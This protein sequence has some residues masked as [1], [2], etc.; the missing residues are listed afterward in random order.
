[1]LVFD[2]LAFIDRIALGLVKPIHA[3]LGISRPLEAI[4][5]L[6]TASLS[7]TA[8]PDRA[9]R[10]NF[11]FNCA[12]TRWKRRIQTTATDAAHQKGVS[13]A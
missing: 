8:T 1:M 3:A 4:T 6:I 9:T 13:L 5:N 2:D 7:R 10:P 11:I 12:A